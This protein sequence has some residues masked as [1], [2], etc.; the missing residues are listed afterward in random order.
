MLCYKILLN[1]TACNILIIILIIF[2]VGTQNPT[3]PTVF[4]IQASDR[5]HCE[6][7]TGAYYQLFRF[8]YKLVYIYIYFEVVYFAKK[9]MHFSK[10]S[11]KFII[12]FFKKR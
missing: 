12:H 9:N 5:V 1:I 11:L 2:S 4:Y 7:E 8:T 6:K 3:P 10:N